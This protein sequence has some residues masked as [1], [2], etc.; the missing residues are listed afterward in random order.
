MLKG[1]VFNFLNFQ[2]KT[3]A[4][5]RPGEDIEIVF[6]GPRP[7]EKLFEEIF[8][9]AWRLGL[10]AVSVYRDGCKMV[11]PVSQSALRAAFGELGHGRGALNGIGRRHGP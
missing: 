1:E 8:R 10:K 9:R 11:Q 2:R 5:P 7:G 4:A 6:T 3:L